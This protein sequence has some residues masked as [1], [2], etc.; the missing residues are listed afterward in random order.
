MFSK[1]SNFTSQIDPRELHAIDDH[2]DVAAAAQAYRELRQE[3]E[4][5]TEALVVVRKIIVPIEAGLL[6]QPTFTTSL[7]DARRERDVLTEQLERA[8]RELARQHDTLESV[9]N[10]ARREIRPLLKEQ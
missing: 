2:P 3:R 1:K 5:I 10:Q 4:R 8:E 7:Q 9:R 6:D